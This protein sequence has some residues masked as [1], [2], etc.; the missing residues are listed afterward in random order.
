M[1]R[2]QNPD[3]PEAEGAGYA[4]PPPI[5]VEDAPA[6]YRDDVSKIFISL[7]IGSRDAADVAIGRETGDGSISR[8]GYGAG[9]AEVSR[10]RSQK[11]GGGDRNTRSSEPESPR[12]EGALADYFSALFDESFC[13]HEVKLVG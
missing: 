11:R 2:Y 4:R 9:D 7:N 12:G 6:E 8:S 1:A 5:D 13:C 3:V 10:G